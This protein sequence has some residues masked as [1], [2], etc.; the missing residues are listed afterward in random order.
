[1]RQA[2]REDHDMVRPCIEAAKARATFGEMT[3]AIYGEMKSFRED[4][5]DLKLRMYA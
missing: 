4:F 2:V 5:R 3:Q 1:L